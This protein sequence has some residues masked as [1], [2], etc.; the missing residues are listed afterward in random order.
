[1]FKYFR[2]ILFSGDGMVFDIEKNM[3]VF[4]RTI[5]IIAGIILVAF[6]I[7]KV[8]SYGTIITI[9]GAF[10]ILTGIVGFC[11]LY[12]PLGISTRK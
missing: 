2:T 9:F 11:I 6:G 10:I 5:R 1:M 12:V 8:P 7:L 4:D 3:G